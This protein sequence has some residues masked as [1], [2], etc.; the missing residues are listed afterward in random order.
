MVE[1]DAAIE[2]LAAT[3]SGEVEH[4]RQ[5]ARLAGRIFEQLAEAVADADRAHELSDGGYLELSCQL[6]ERQRDVAAAESDEEV[7]L[8]PQ[9]VESTLFG[10]ERG[11]FTGGQYRRKGKIEM[12]NRD[13][14]RQVM[15]FWRDTYDQSQD[16]RHVHGTA[17]GLT[18]LPSWLS[19]NR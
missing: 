1:R 5:V 4:G 19:R 15:Q 11:A 17:G 18:A 6:L 16:R 10:H 13:G 3:C 14:F 2:R 9:L 8:P 7:E 12:A